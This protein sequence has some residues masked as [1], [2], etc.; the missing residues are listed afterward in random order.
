MTNKQ[1]GRN[2]ICP[3]GSGLKYKKCCLKNNQSSSIAT[4]KE[5]TFSND[6]MLTMLKLTLENLSL[7]DTKVK[8][9][10]VKSLSF[11]GNDTLVC[12]FYAE[13]KVAIEV[14]IEIGTLMGALNGFFKDDAF[15]N[16]R[17]LNFA[18]RAFDS[19]DTEIMYA[20]CS[21]ENAKQI[22]KGESIDWMKSTIFQENTND[23]RLSIA[24]RQISELE[25]TLRLIISERLYQ[26]HGKNWF[27]K[28]VGGK[29]RR[30]IID[31]YENQ[32]GEK[33][34]DGS[35]LIEY[36]FILQLK[37]II[38]SNWKLFSDL[39]DS[40]DE[41][42]SYMLELNRIRREESHNRNITTNDLESLNTISEFLLT[43]ITEKYPE[44]SPSF[45]VD[46]WKE[47]LKEI[48]F[49]S[50]EFS[51]TQTE[52]IEEN[53]NLLKVMKSM[54]NSYDLIN[55]LKDKK[56]RIENLH[57]PTSK[58]RTNNELVDI[59]SNMINAQ[60]ELLELVKKGELELAEKKQ[61]EIDEYQ[62]VVKDFSDKFILVES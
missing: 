40:E 39:F 5:K 13:R 57:V 27:L 43:E 10:K 52:I 23:Y 58:R 17:I 32:F 3:C 53:S 33:I 62:V 9:I 4:T 48:M 34:E 29:L 6:E 61:I 45:L 59:L 38:C 1:I 22:G 14:K 20:L 24:K 19:T 36:T 35:V 55:Y 25:N 18:V 47:Q 50:F 21:K 28:A 37:T 15:P 31:T 41:L 11:I 16:I 56:E 7:V 2:D 54:T 51:Y 49:G 60:E 8:N 12:E 26:K 30:R 44:I 46:R 42:E